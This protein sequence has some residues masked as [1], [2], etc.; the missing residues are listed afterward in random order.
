MSAFT[1]KQTMLLLEQF[2][3][4]HCKGSMH[5]LREN[6]R[7]EFTMPS[8]SEN[9]SAWCGWLSHAQF[10]A[11]VEIKSDGRED[12]NTAL[13]CVTPVNLSIIPSTNCDRANS[14]TKDN[15]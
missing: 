15:F 11:N 13:N 5:N 1:K 7:G 12:S 6:E 8:I 14:P 3:Q 4:H 10:I 2:V 9:W